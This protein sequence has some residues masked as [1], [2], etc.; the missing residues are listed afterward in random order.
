MLTVVGGYG[1]GL[2]MR[3]AHAPRGG[4]TVGGATFS[5]SHGGKGSNQAVAAARAG[6]RVALV[7][8]V[9]DDD[10]A[11][12]A[13]ALWRAEG[14]DDCAIVV[15]GVPTMT[16]FIVVDES[17]ENRIVI[18]DGALGAVTA[19]QL[20]PVASVLETSGTVVVSLEIAHEAAAEAVRLAAAAGARVVLNPAPATARARELLAEVDVLIPNQS[21]L[22]VL[23]GLEEVDDLDRACD[24]VRERFTGVLIVTLGAD[25]V[26]VDDGTVRRRIPAF[27]AA[28]VDTTGAGDAFTGAFAAV[29]DEGRDVMDAARFAAAAAALAVGRAEVVPG[30]ATRA[31]TL[32]LMER[33][34]PIERA[35]ETVG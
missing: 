32:S 25:G 26:L 1:R 11:R 10:A 8:A 34:N 4:E 18:A 27:P 2:T 9:G 35:K 16:G 7:T 20:D 13:R 19:A 31:E 33:T 30:L 17:G 28:V 29:W 15:P 23:A 6:A 12:E 24:L 14:V 21:E 3:V 5:A 22:A